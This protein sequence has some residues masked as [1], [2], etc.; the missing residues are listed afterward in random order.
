LKP[1]PQAAFH[2]LIDNAKLFGLGASWGGYESLIQPSSLEGLRTSSPW[3][4][5]GPLFRIHAGLEHPDDLVAS[6][7]E[8]FGRMRALL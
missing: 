1:V 7:D 3:P 4:H 6:L 2:A 8:A 5:P